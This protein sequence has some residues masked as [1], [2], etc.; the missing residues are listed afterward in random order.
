MGDRVAVLRDGTLQQLAT[1]LELYESPANLFV[2]SFIGSPP[3]NLY[4]AEISGPQVNSC[5]RLVRSG[6]PSQPM[7][8]IAPR[9]GRQQDSQA[10]GRDP[11]E[12]LTIADG[13]GTDRE[14]TLAARVELVEI[15]ATNHSFITRRT[16]EQSATERACDA[17]CHRAR[18]DRGCGR[19][20][21]RRT[22]RSARAR[23]GR[24]PGHLRR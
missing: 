23:R 2:A 1:P 4:E 18:R 17:R 10:R 21:R 9:L 19:V 6:L 8:D 11:S 5:S 16:R 14:T 12:H 13:A 20:R 24:R 22:R 15:S 7:S 3:M